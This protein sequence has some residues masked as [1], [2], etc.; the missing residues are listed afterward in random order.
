MNA[1]LRSCVFCWALLCSWCIQAAEPAVAVYYG[2]KASLSELGLYDIAVVEPD[3]GYDPVRFRQQS[4]G[5]ELYAYASVAEV[6][7]DRAY[8]RKIPA[9][10]KLARNGAWRSIVIDQ[11]PAQWPAFFADEVIAPLWD[12]GF[13]GFFL[14][15]LD[16]YRL[17]ANFD[18]AAQQEGLVRVIDTLHQRFPG[19]RL[20]L[21]RGFEIVP[22][23]RDKIQMVA[24]ESLYRGWD[25]NLKRY[26]DIPAKDRE[27]LL[28]QLQAIRERDKLPVLAIDYV[29]PHDRDAT[30]DTARRIAQLGIIPWVSDADL[31][32]L[33]IGSVETVARRVLVL[34]NGADD[35]A[36]NYSSAHRFLEMP[37]NYMGYI[38]DYADV[39]SPLPAD[40]VRDR[41]A[42]VVSWF[43]GA[44]PDA[45]FKDVRA[46]LT[47]QMQQGMPVLM[48]DAP[49]IPLDRTLMTT[50]G[51]RSMEA[52]PAF[53][54][55]K[56]EQSPL[57]GF[58]AEPADP[59]HD[60]SGWLLT[61]QMLQQS[62]QLLSFDDAKGQRFVSAAIT[63]WGGFAMS[64]YVVAD[65]PGTEQSRWVVDPFKLLKQALRLPDFPVP[66]VTTENGRRLLMAHVDGDGFPSRAEAPGAPFAGE[67][68]RREILERYR[69]PHTIS[70]IEAEVS[71][72]GLYPR[73]AD[74]LEGIAR[75]I[76]A[77]PNV[78]I[79][80]HSY[81][82]P[83]LWDRTVSH[84]LFAESKEVDLNLNIPGYQMDL[85]R[86]IEG[87]VDYIRRRLAPEGKPVK[88]F[89]WTGDTAPSAE[90][91][92]I[93][94]AA[95][96][97]NMNGGDTSITRSNPSLTEV[98]S[99]GI[100]KGG[101]LQIYA[102]VT[103]E[104]IYTNLWHGPF[105]GF[106]RVIETFEMTDAP[107]RLKA[108]DIYYHS[109]SASKQAS[110]KALHKAYGWAMSHRLH[111]VYASEYIRKVADFYEFAI[112]R[113]GDAWR[114]RGPGQL[115]T[116]RLP[117]GMGVPVVDA[118]SGIAGYVKGVDGYYLHLVNGA[119]RVKMR[120]EAAAAAALPYLVDAN[121]RL[122]EWQPQP[123]GGLRLTLEGHVP[124]ELRM[125][126]PPGCSLSSA[127]NANPISAVPASDR[128]AIRSFRS[129]HN[130]A[131]LQAQCR[132]L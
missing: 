98:K 44:I 126:L 99:W 15:T 43:G 41:Y 89:L 131:Q 94:D 2:S 26:V 122:G 119:A 1:F 127:S 39:R 17:A 16:S 68:L 32:T 76:F 85:R 115:R 125:Y 82:H 103:N 77:M 42:G 35:P 88:V 113:E 112:G 22:R 46:W 106:E 105:Y 4:P 10:W 101:H 79:A 20:I 11:T 130:R 56:A 54:L 132:A 31:Q 12:K 57:M 81:S 40:V 48:M 51:V 97:L 78:E 6:L 96:L 34:Y 92:A 29:A 58:E 64:P 69:I 60:Y 121:A 18:E 7:P 55:K 100:R 129:A 108:V 107:R 65:I 109:Y 59:A 3:H 72:Q 87:S 49:G 67:M 36:L 66:D 83:Y 62:R 28:Q 52:A 80:S 123:D 104:N 110:L 117:P 21:N 33:G 124:L 9:E 47:R 37:I 91:L 70:V 24:A 102:P 14:D 90:A 116:L 53:P 73:W 71:P 50:L 95:G 23:V 30:R 63:P 8:F 93:S 111:P 128:S 75:R 86:E 114:L 27:W 38:V 5:S 120:E 118:G 25:A 61:P 13:R 45:R 74:Q 84:G 19:I